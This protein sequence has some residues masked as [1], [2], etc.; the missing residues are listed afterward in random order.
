MTVQNAK[1]YKCRTIRDFCESLYEDFFKL[2][3]GKIES[4]ATKKM[5]LLTRVR[6]AELFGFKKWTDF[7]SFCINSDYLSLFVYFEDKNK[8]ISNL[9]KPYVYANQT[10]KRM[11]V[12]SLLSI[13]CL[14]GDALES[15]VEYF[16]KY[17]YKNMPVSLKYYLNNLFN[18]INLE[19]NIE[20]ENEDAIYIVSNLLNDMD[21][22]RLFYVLSTV[23]NLDINAILQARFNWFFDSFFKLMSNKKTLPNWGDFT[24][25]NYE[26]LTKKILSEAVNRKLITI[27]ELI[28]IYSGIDDDWVKKDFFSHAH[29]LFN[30]RRGRVS[31]IDALLWIFDSNISE[32]DKDALSFYEK[33]CH[34]QEIKAT[35]VKRNP[36]EVLQT[37]GMRE[38]TSVGDIAPLLRS[39]SILAAPVLATFMIFNNGSS[40]M[41]IEKLFAIFYYLGKYKELT[42]LVHKLES[43]A[44]IESSL[45]Y[46]D[47]DLH[48]EII[49]ATVLARNAG[50]INTDKDFDVYLNLLIKIFIAGHYRLVLREYSRVIELTKLAIPAKACSEV[51]SLALSKL[52][53]N[54]LL[55]LSQ[56]D[57]NGIYLV[58][59]R[60]DCDVSRLTPH[61]SDAVKELSSIFKETKTRNIINIKHSMSK[62]DIIHAARALELSRNYQIGFSTEESIDDKTS[63]I[64]YI[65]GARI[66]EDN[67]KIRGI[68]KHIAV[69]EYLAEFMKN[70]L[71]EYR[72]RNRQGNNLQ[73]PIESD[74]ALMS[75]N[76]KALY[77]KMN[78][79]SIH[80]SKEMIARL[81]IEGITPSD[82]IT[83]NSHYLVAIKGMIMYVAGSLNNPQLLCSLICQHKPK[84]IVVLDI[85]VESYFSDSKHRENGFYVND[86]EVLF[87]KIDD[88]DGAII[89]RVFDSFN[90]LKL[91]QYEGLNPLEGLSDKMAPKFE[92]KGIV[93]NKGGTDYFTT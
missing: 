74:I 17:H 69:T 89:D 64:L 81:E 80:S 77:D 63:L 91:N 72:F 12:S 40:N 24:N 87:D 47:S 8:E 39:K 88:L 61:I 37:F 29:R 53:E 79:D 76:M 35:V 1:S 52:P 90:E 43:L 20:L 67:T 34:T 66:I 19:E 55:S 23:N 2:K 82:I 57:K 4:L 51:F 62:N 42:P 44:R 36:F 50:S 27:N 28:D 71:N 26:S 65:A 49:A 48:N 15:D 70:R 46:S 18:E 5:V 56:T 86:K 78:K 3:D 11:S 21:F 6:F 10:K 92:Y 59:L 9:S 25:I 58:M 41:S 7:C 73:Y 85:E 83:L 30:T 38:D 31:L 75:V 93:F 14:L 45:S 68:R 13:K 16:E 84:K 60:M 33:H 54:E 32:E 22:P